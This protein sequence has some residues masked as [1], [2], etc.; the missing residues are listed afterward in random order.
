VQFSND[1]VAEMSDLLVPELCGV[2]DSLSMSYH[3]D[4][5][6]LY[7]SCRNGKLLRFTIREGGLQLKDGLPVGADLQF[8]GMGNQR[9]GRADT[10]S[11]V[12][13]YLVVNPI[14]PTLFP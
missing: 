8:E 6:S 5:K 4:L 2:T 14:I 13:T 10:Y 12:L 1:D 7:I 11:K 3:V 9:R